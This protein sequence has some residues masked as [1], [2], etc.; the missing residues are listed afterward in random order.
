[1]VRYNDERAKQFETNYIELQNTLS[2][3]I[4]K[5]LRLFKHFL[6]KRG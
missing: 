4:T 1:M 6:V 3:K 2:W 5:P